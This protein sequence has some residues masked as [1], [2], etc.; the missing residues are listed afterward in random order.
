[1]F[2]HLRTLL[3]EGV[4][5]RPLHF[6]S[7]MHSPT[8]IRPQPKDQGWR[9]D[10]AHGGGAMFEM[11]SHA[12]DLA[13]YLFGRPADVGGT[14]LTR[15]YSAGVE[16]IVAGNL[17]YADGLAGSLYINWSDPSYRKPTNKIE[18]FGERGRA[19]ADQHGMRLHL[20]EADPA[21]GYQAGWNQIS[22]TSVAEPVAFYL[23]GFEFTAQLHDFVDHVRSGDVRT[24]CDFDDGTAVIEVIEAMFRDHART[25]G[26]AA[27]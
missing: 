16:D 2:A 25:S 23:R 27:A 7:D 5:G 26:G 17:L 21:R 15:V 19:L 8:I 22:I 3:A 20:S 1:M 4:I 10:H 12:I 24:L 18:I 14:R 13:L 6:R 11:A 9:G